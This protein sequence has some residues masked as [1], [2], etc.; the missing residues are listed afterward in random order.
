MPL[1]LKWSQPR[2]VWTAPSRV[3]PSPASTT[4]MVRHPSGTV[5]GKVA[6]RLCS[7]P[8]ASTHSHAASPTT[9]SSAA[10]SSRSPV[11][12]SARRTPLASA[13]R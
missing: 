9:D 1:R 11:G 13:M 7:S 3:T 8:P 4:P 6:S 12:E 5:S 10:W 2:A